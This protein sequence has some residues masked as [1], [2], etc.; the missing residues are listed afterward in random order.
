MGHS[1]SKPGLLTI[2]ILVAASVILAGCATSGTGGSTGGGGQQTGNT[3]NILLI[4]STF[5]S[6][7]SFPAGGQAD[8]VADISN[9]GPVS[10]RNVNAVFYNFGPNIDGCPEVF[11]GDIAP[12]EA[13]QVV[14]TVT[15]KDRSSWADSTQTSF[16]QE[17]SVKVQYSF[18]V[19]GAYESIKVLSPDE[20]ARTS[21]GAK[22]ESKDVS[23]GPVR[24]HVEFQNQPAQAG[25]EFPILLSFTA[26]KSDTEG[27]ESLRDFEVSSAQL[28]IPV[29]FAVASKGGFSTIVPNCESGYTCLQASDWDISAKNGSV[30]RATVAPPQISVP[31]ETYSAR[32]A[33]SGFTVFKI[34]TKKVTVSESPGG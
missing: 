13:R 31:Q 12:G 6:A 14:C 29:V 15:A 28:Q 26:R 33:A 4:A 7:Q 2:T 21:P 3:E 25:K 23:M 34:A 24:L 18:D 1:T 16:T 22:A 17:V 30:L 11:V 5:S 32:F 27:I 20:F 9:A 19:S 8:L 10:L